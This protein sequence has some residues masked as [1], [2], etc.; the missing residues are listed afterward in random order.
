MCVKEALRSSRKTVDAIRKSPQSS[1]DDRASPLGKAKNVA[2][3]RQRGSV[4]IARRVHRGGVAVRH[5]PL[6]DG[7]ADVDR[8]A[9]QS[10]AEGMPLLPIALR[11]RDLL[12]RGAQVGALRVIAAIAS[13]QQECA[14]LPG[15]MRARQHMLASGKVAW[16][17]FAMPPPKLNDHPAAAITTVVRCLQ[18]ARSTL[19]LEQPD[20]ARGGKGRGHVRPPTPNPAP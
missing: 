17:L 6:I 5:Q 19:L 1:S 7:R 9:A 15:F 20:R 12:G 8:R 10:C 13:E 4:W 2:R 3:W 16:R 14:A 11:Q 18:V